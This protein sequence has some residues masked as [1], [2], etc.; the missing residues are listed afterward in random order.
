MRIVYIYKS[1]ALLAGME[2]ILSDKM[3][4]LSENNDIEIYLITYEQ[5]NHPIS[6]PLNSKITHIDIDVKFYSTHGYPLGKRMIMY[7]N[8]RYLFS[9]RLKKNILKI[10]PDIIVT[11]TY[12][13]PIL[14]LIIGIS[15]TAKYI[16]ESHVAKESI[17]KSYGFTNPILKLISRFYDRYMIR[18]I[19][20]FDKLITLTNH[21]KLSWHEVPQSMVIPNSIK[22]SKHRA[23]LDSH[24]VISVG[25]LHEQKGFDLLIKAWNDVHQK[26][27]DWEIHIY[28]D[29]SQKDILL[30]LINDFGLQES[31]FIHQPSPNIYDEYLKYSFYVMSSRYEGFGLVLAEAM[32]C[33]LPCISF[34]CPH[35]PA[36]IIKHN[37]DGLLVNNGDIKHLSDSI[38]LLIENDYLRKEMGEKACKNIQRYSEYLIKKQWID[39]FNTL[40]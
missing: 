25:R 24:K 39:L 32:S 19:K 8:M 37:E 28:G 11:T 13:Y 27:S 20:K 1:I 18:Q 30:K 29:G 17:L 7:L 21:D 2:R 16:L 26:Y 10:N 38:S 6:F 36:D 33:G 40:M 35:G 9:K 31:V 5:S 15:K 3:N 12:S 34:N 4:Y 22:L 14:D 23:L